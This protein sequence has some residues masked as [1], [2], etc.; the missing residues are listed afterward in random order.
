MRATIVIILLVLVAGCRLPA[1]GRSPGVTTLATADAVA[2]GAVLYAAYCGGCHGA[3]GRGD[4]PITEVLD[5]EPTNLRAPGLLDHATDREVVDRVLHGAPLRATPRRSAV[6]EDLQVDAITAYLPTLARSDWDVLRAGRFV[7]EGACAPCH[8]AYGEGEGF[9]GATNDPPPPNLLKAREHYTDAALARI[10]VVG[11]G[12]MPPL[13][14]AFQPGEIRAVVAYVRH[15][16][17]GYRLYD[18]FCASCHGDD[19]RGVHPEDLLSPSMVA[20]RLD[21]DTLKRLGPTAA[22]A[23][24]LHMVRRE[25][26]RMPHFRDTLT[27][28]QL[29]DIVAYL[30]RSGAAAVVPTK[31]RTP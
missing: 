1:G 8:G 6:A 3:L 29:F 20:P 17:K 9:F 27:E 30:R 31:G 26:G 23:K 24:I 4:G 28:G 5:L 19:G 22:R 7:F 21:G 12:D 18:T 11:Q 14:D 10:S 2:R 13:A 15:L 25:S 16:S